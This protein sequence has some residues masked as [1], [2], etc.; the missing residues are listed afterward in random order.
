LPLSDGSAAAVISA[1]LETDPGARCRGIESA[2]YDDPALAVWCAVHPRRKSPPR[3]LRELAHWLDSCAL[4]VLQWGEEPA[5][6]VESASRCRHAERAA[7]GMVLAEAAERLVAADDAGRIRLLAFLSG[8]YEW[9]A[10]CCTP[11]GPDALEQF[12]PSWLRRMI[13]ALRESS[14]SEDPALQAVK[15][16][17]QLPNR[18]GDTSELAAAWS[19]HVPFAAETLPR[20]S[21]RLARLADLEGDF[22]TTLRREKLASLQKL[23]YGASH[24]INN[25]L[26]NIA[27]RAQALLQDEP[28]PERQRALATINDQ[29]FRAFEMIANMMLFA[30]PPELILAPTD[31]HELLRRTVA[32]MKPS[33][34]QQ[35]TAMVLR[36]GKE[37]LWIQ[38]DGTQLAV[39]IRAL[40]RN[41]LEAVEC[42]GEVE[43]VVRRRDD[44]RLELAV[45]DTGPGL[46]DEARRHLF[47][48]FYSSREAGR[49]LGFGLSWCWTIVELHRGEIAVESAPGRGTTFTVLLPVEAPDAVER[50]EV[51]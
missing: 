34:E 51:A 22:D 2:L 12:A 35:G 50:G 49:G 37:A 21:S 46:S 33:A 6:D 4:S 14:A 15:R 8:A 25:P 9:L 38:A 32:E 44:D 18:N 16:A 29:A 5:A 23:A 27:T 41:A 10:A 47:D 13:A 7:Q 39:L 42:G 24:E 3:D 17:L 1:L 48:P 19:C 20:L 40:V 30:K 31:V 28:D 26:A 11:R 45:R 36:A 43:I